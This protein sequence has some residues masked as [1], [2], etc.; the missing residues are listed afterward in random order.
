MSESELQEIERRAK[1]EIEAA[2]KFAKESPYPDA[3]ELFEDVYV[4]RE[5]R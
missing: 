3:D 5:E 2:E 1:E 4:E